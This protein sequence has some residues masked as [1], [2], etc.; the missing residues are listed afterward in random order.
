MEVHGSLGK[1]GKK[2]TQKL[3]EELLLLNYLENEIK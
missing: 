1:W 2:G 3:V